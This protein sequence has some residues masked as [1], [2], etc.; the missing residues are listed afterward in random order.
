MADHDDFMTRCKEK[1]IDPNDLDI[2]VVDI[3]KGKIKVKYNFEN[4]LIQIKY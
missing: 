1:D 2:V 4:C 3:S